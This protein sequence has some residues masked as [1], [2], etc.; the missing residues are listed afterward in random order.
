MAEQIS[1]TGNKG[2]LWNLMVEAD[3][4]GGVPPDKKQSVIE[5]T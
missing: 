3:V 5:I 1:S 2:F 4:F